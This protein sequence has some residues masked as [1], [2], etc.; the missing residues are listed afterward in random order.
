MLSGSLRKGFVG[1]MEVVGDGNY[2]ED[3]GDQTGHARREYEAIGEEGGEPHPEAELA[4]Q[5]FADGT[6][7]ATAPGL[8]VDALGALLILAFGEWGADHAGHRVVGDYETELVGRHPEQDDVLCLYPFGEGASR[9]SNDQKK[10]GEDQIEESGQRGVRGEFL[11]LG[12]VSRK[13]IRH[14]VV[15]LLRLPHLIAQN[16]NPIVD[17]R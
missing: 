8:L 11:I 14:P 10:S 4:G 1:L 13:D 9:A 3:R 17:D 2:G 16:L 7:Q 12:P 6:A 15:I 5:Q